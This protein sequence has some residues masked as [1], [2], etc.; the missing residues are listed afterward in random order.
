MIHGVQL[1][2]GVWSGMAQGVH[3]WPKADSARFTGFDSLDASETLAGG[4]IGGRQEDIGVERC[5]RSDA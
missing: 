3:A 1:S 4:G 2:A 5:C